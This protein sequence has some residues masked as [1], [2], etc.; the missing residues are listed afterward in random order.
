MIYTV[1]FK[2][3]DCLEHLLEQVSDQDH[4]DTEQKQDEI[5]R[6]GQIAKKFIRWGEYCYVEIDTDTMTFKLQEI[7]Q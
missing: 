6:I 4:L 2:T 3:P 1:T 5:E 7:K